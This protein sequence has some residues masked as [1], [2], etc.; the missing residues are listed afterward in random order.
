MIDGDMADHWSWIDD[1]GNHC[2][3]LFY[4]TIMT[5]RSIMNFTLCEF[6]LGFT[7]I[8]KIGDLGLLG[9]S[10]IA[11]AVFMML[12]SLAKSDAPTIFKTQRKVF[13]FYF[14]FAGASLNDFYHKASRP[15]FYSLLIH[16]GFAV[17][18]ELSS[19]QLDEQLK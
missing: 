12:P 9:I 4:L 13:C 5:F 19:V 15:R 6:C 1:F 14:S 18:V 10:F 2:R 16:I 8:L 3:I 7:E 11:L 17:I